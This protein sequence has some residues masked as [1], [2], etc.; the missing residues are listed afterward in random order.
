MMIWDVLVSVNKDEMYHSNK[1][2]YNTLAYISNNVF[3]FFIYFIVDFCFVSFILL[4]IY[5][6]H[7]IEGKFSV[8]LIIHL[9]IYYLL[10]YMNCMKYLKI[11]FYKHKWTEYIYCRIAKNYNNPYIYWIIFNCFFQKEDFIIFH[12]S[13]RQN[14]S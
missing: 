6:F 14:S 9:F 4:F 8:I 13:L 10:M 2:W 12:F 5:L 1:L 7:I 11:F 3:I